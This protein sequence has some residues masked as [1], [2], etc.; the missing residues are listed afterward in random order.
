ML[1]STTVGTS[2]V[3]YGKMEPDE[4]ESGIRLRRLACFRG[5][6]WQAGATRPRL[7]AGGPGHE[8]PRSGGRAG[9]VA[10]RSCVLAPFR[11]LM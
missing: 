2:E 8:A 5:A 10:K 4:T 11:R 3:F 7:L 6:S 9:K 1:F